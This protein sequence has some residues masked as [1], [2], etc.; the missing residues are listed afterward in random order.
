MTGTENANTPDQWL[1]RTADNKITGPF[2]RRE[3]CQFIQQGKLQAN[4]E[5]CRANNFWFYLHEHQEI[6]DQLGMELPKELCPTTEES[7]QTE[8]DVE[9]SEPTDPEIDIESTRVASMGTAGTVRGA[10]RPRD[11][12]TLPEFD[13]TFEDVGENTAVMSNRA[14]RDYRQPGTGPQP[15]SAAPLSAPVVRGG[16]SVERSKVV[17]ILILV[18]M[19]GALALLFFVIRRLQSQ[20]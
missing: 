19:I 18:M 2:T 7:T 1:I 6:R 3:V 8:T 20:A 4:D 5:V 12:Q 13:E 15:Q 14:F 11:A 16:M 9:L 17:Q 10:V